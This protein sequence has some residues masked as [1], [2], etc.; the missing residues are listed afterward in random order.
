MFITKPRCRSLDIYYTGVYL[1]CYA[2]KFVSA[3]SLRFQASVHSIPWIFQTCTTWR[4][5]RILCATRFSSTWSFYSKFFKR[6]SSPCRHFMSSGPVTEISR[7]TTTLILLGS[8]YLLSV[9]SVSHMPSFLASISFW[10]AHTATVAFLAQ[11]FYAYRISILAQSYW[12]PGLI[13]TVRPIPNSDIFCCTDAIALY[14]SLP[15]SSWLEQ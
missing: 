11:S 15:L 6:S 14:S 4:S 9:G 3:K 13:L 10:G 8:M 7:L 1:A 5:Q 2:L 12:V